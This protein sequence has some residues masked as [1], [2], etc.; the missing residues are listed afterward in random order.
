MDRFSNQIQGY[1][2]QNPFS[3]S[4]AR[5]FSDTKVSNEFYPISSFWSLFND[6][7]EV[8]L[9]TRGCGKTFL[10]KMMRYS[11]LKKIRDPR[12]NEIIEKKEF[13]GLYV[14]MHLEF[15]TLFN[16]QNIPTDQQILLFQ[17]AFNCLLAESL[18]IELQSLIDEE[19]NL[20]ERA[21]KTA[22]IV[23]VLDEIWF[24]VKNS[25]IYEMETLR[26]KVNKVFY[27]IDWKHPILESIPV[28]FRRQIC[29]S[30][31]SVKTVIGQCFKW[32]EEPTWIICIDEAEFLNET[33]QKCINSMFRSDTSRIALKIA[34]L[35]FFHK[36]L[37]TLDSSI[38]VVNGNDFSYRVIDMLYSS[39]D[40]VNLSNSLC[41]H[42]LR[43]RFN[44]DH[45]CKSLEE[46]LGVIGKDDQIDYFRNQFGEKEAQME[47]IEK[48]IIAS[49]PTKRRDAAGAYSN[50]RK[51]I[52]DKYAPIYFVR[53]MYALSKKGNSK[54][55]WF[56]GAAVVRKVSQGNPRLFIQLMSELFERARRT[57]L[58]P[59]NQSEVILKFAENICRSTKALE[60]QGPKIYQELEK[61]AEYLHYKTH[62]GN[63]IS[64]GCAFTLKY[65]D[66][67]EF[68]KSKMWLQ[69]AVAYSR[70][71][72]EDDI[73]VNGI[74][75]T[76]KYLLA[77]T[78]AAAYWLPMRGDVPT[79]ISV[80]A[81][82]SNRYLVENIQK[83]DNNMHQISLFEEDNE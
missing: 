59:K 38:S 46:F 49:F 10:L 39:S 19:E 8:L 47:Y 13:I 69:L 74:T 37:E 79:K 1:K 7:H 83:K 75:E 9:G 77:N 15:V 24:D 70:L 41:S 51:T 33:L 78:Y 54:P 62:E 57:Q 65:L 20:I 34:T 60:A 32:K 81:N 26:N 16:N 12:A 22:N 61:I 28:I 18:I 44:K 68:E 25:E 72:V 76:T 2:A 40:F 43:S 66:N 42:R 31:A 71:I 35:P 64:V 11:M 48:Q 53:E 80:N 67:Q 30:L 82:V 58:D 3:D 36:T 52:Y 6:Q 50:R 23:R 14:P 73:K 4:Q 63:L 45:I 56:A 21:K 17:S 5:N 29:S 55:G 27:N